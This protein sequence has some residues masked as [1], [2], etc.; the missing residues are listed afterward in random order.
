MVLIKRFKQYRDFIDKRGN[1]PESSCLGQST[2]NDGYFLRRSVYRL[3]FRSWLQKNAS[4]IETKIILNSKELSYQKEK[5]MDASIA[6]QAC[7][8]NEF[9][10]LYD[11][12]VHLSFF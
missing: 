7:A 5:K 8:K 10:V 9:D 2:V 11:M 4:E 6:P 12:K 3:H 1:L